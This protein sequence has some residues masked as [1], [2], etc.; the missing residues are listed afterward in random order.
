MNQERIF[1]V[2]LAPHVSEKASV[3]ADKN[4]QYVFKVARD[5]SKREIKKAVEQLFDVKVEAIQ[6]LNVKGKRKVF[7]RVQGKRSDWKKAYVSLQAGQDID[8]LAAE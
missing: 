3:V 4:G 2:L 5:A 6:T 1:Q 7:G 8:F